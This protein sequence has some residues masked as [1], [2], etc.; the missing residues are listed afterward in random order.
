MR[1][2]WEIKNHLKIPIPDSKSQNMTAVNASFKAQTVSNCFHLKTLWKISHCI[3]QRSPKKRSSMYV[4][5]VNFRQILLACHHFNCL[6]SITVEIIFGWQDKNTN[7]KW[8]WN[9][10]NGTIN[11]AYAVSNSSQFYI[12]SI[13]R[14]VLFL[15]VVLCTLFHV[16]TDVSQRNQSEWANYCLTWQ[17]IEIVRLSNS[18]ATDSCSYGNRFANRLN[19]I[20]LQAMQMLWH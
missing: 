16:M 4:N 12:N 2:F 8:L 3:Y 1:L 14:M 15:F 11:N 5:A 13:N 6:I 17:K 10:I 20:C 18:L 9:R 7:E 19:S